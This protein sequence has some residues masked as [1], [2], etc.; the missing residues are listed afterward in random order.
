MAVIG[1]VVVFLRSV[2]SGPMAS[3]LSMKKV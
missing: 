2:T 3:D 1:A